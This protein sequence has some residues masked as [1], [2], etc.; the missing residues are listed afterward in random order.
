M[1]DIRRLDLAM[2]LIAPL[3][4]GVCVDTIHETYS[5]VKIAMPMVGSLGAGRG[6]GLVR[7]LEHETDTST[8]EKYD[9]CCCSVCAHSGYCWYRER[10]KPGRSVTAVA[11]PFP[12]TSS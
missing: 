3:D 1:V 5:H 8:V 9:G 7:N 4:G 10:G 11:L 6:A 12:S 2:S